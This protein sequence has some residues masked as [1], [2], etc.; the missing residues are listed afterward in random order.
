MS[1]WWS[2]LNPF[3]QVHAEE[4]KEEE[5]DSEDSEDKSTP[6]QLQLY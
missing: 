5:K 6:R 3:V 4:A 1:S 2:A